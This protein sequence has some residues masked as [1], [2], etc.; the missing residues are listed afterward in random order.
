MISY[1]SFFY[2]FNI[3]CVK[4]NNYFIPL[5]LSYLIILVNA[6]DVRESAIIINILFK[7]SQ[8]PCDQ[9]LM[10]CYISVGVC[11]R[12]RHAS[13]SRILC[14]QNCAISCNL[15]DPFQVIRE[16]FSTHRLRFLIP[17]YMS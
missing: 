2:V 8:L 7:A 15:L 10:K 11:K 16:T 6:S 9:H 12:R 14:L 17:S 1:I 5:T 13:G 4:N 3:L